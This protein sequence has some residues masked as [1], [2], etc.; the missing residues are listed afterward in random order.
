MAMPGSDPQPLSV[1]PP[2]SDS[3]RNGTEDSVAPP[4][5]HRMSQRISRDEVAH[6][7]NLA[8]LSVSD[9]EL[10]TYTEQLGS[11]LDYVAQ[12]E[13][14]DTASVE[15]MAHPLPLKNVLRADERRPSLDRD[16]VLS[17][18]PEREG[19][20]FYVPRILSEEP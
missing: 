7:A 10:D 1:S 13:A 3:D 20:Y 6:V 14:L 19:P 15:P 4:T 2:T 17:Q 18:A 9:E 12:V 5:I 8:R 16:E 11:I